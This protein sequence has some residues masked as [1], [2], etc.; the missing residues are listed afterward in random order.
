MECIG[1]I[2]HRIFEKQVVAVKNQEKLNCNV[3]MF[4]LS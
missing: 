4:F 2:P 1:E 3:V